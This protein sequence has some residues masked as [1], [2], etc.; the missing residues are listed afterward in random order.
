[1]EPSCGVS[2]AVAYDLK[3]YL[4]DQE[5]KN[6]VVVVCG[7]NTLDLADLLKFKQQFNL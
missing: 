3:K 1:M 2:L 5:F 6:V 4:P 7:G